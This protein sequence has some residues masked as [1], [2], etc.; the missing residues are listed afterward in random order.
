MKSMLRSQRKNRG[1]AM[2]GLEDPGVWCAYVLCIV[3]VIV[4]VIY[5]AVNWNKGDEP[6]YPEDVK[7]VKDEKEASDSV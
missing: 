3:C 2:L 5:G 6:V 1:G 4:C 7:W